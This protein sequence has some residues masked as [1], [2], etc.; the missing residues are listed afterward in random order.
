[1]IGW[2]TFKHSV[3]VKASTIRVIFSLAV[4]YGREIQQ[5]DVN[6]AFLNGTF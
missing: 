5:M 4:T 6:N 1:M 3:I 2:Y